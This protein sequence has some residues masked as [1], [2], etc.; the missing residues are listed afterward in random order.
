MNNSKALRFLSNPQILSALIW[1][2]TIIGCSYVSDR[3]TIS[4]ILITAAGF[5]VVL[6]TQFAKTKPSE[7]ID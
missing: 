4:T 1:A 6:M 2:V 3:S 7:A 5:H